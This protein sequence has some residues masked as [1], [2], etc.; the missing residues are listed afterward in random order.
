MH[1]PQFRVRTAL[2][3]VAFIGLTL[4]GWV[5]YGRIYAPRAV[6]REKA[7]WFAHAA[8]GMRQAIAEHEQAYVS[9]QRSIDNA[10]PN[11]PVEAENRKVIESLRKSDVRA[12]KLIVFWEGLRSRYEE[13]YRRPWMHVPPDPPLPN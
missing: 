1:A 4:G 5:F 3:L 11:S 2:I 8:E 6:Y 9:L 10:G 7:H 12:R 13:A